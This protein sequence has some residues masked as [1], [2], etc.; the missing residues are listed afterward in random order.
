MS[1]PVLLF[2][3]LNDPVAGVVLHDSAVSSL[4]EMISLFGRI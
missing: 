1:K 2:Y 4:S 3:S